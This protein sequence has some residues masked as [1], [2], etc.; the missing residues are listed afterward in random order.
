M[1]DSRKAF[2]SL[3]NQRRKS[4]L[5]QQQD[6]AQLTTKYLDDL[7]Q[8]LEVVRTLLSAKNYTAIKK[9][10]HRIKGTSGTYHLDA[11]ARNASVLE[12]LADNQ[13]PEAIASAIDNIK[14]SV[15]VETMN[16]NSGTASA[17]KPARLVND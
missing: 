6:W 10:A 11:I 13:N 16:L 17:D 12:G 3:S 8:Q 2:D 1:E 7:P 4:K 9:H 15:D 5:G 14:Q